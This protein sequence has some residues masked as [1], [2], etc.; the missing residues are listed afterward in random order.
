MKWINTY[1]SEPGEYIYCAMMSC[2]CCVDY[3]GYLEIS[4]NK[5][6]GRLLFTYTKEEKIFYVF[7]VLDS[8]LQDSL[9]NDGFYWL[10]FEPPAVIRIPI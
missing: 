4:N 10:S 2:E 9:E 7:G 8:K 1:P 5:P 6:N 3:V